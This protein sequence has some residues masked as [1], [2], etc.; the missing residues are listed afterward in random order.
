VSIPVGCSDGLP[1]GMSLFGP[2]R[3]AD[4][5]PVASAVEHHAAVPTSPPPIKEKTS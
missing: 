2:A 1:V 3:L 5:L 4:L